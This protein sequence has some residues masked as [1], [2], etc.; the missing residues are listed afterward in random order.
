MEFPIIFGNYENLSFIVE[1]DGARTVF[2]PEII[3]D[4][5]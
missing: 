3:Y 5:Y 1:F 4:D 2:G